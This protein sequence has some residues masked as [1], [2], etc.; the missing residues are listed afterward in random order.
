MS[1]STSYNIT[2]P[3]IQM[4][5]EYEGVKYELHKNILQYG[6]E[7]N[8]FNKTF[9]LYF[10]KTYHNKILNSNDTF[11]IHYMDKN[12]NMG[13]FSSNDYIKL[14]TLAYNIYDSNNNVIT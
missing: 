6:I 5:L 12:I 2:Y 9:F 3:F 7:N 4:E 14:T 8:I 10:M 1:M 11:K 13:T